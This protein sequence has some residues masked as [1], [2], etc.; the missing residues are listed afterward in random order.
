M[1]NCAA[2]LQ[3]KKIRVGTSLIPHRVRLF[4]RL[5]ESG[6]GSAVQPV[7]TL[8]KQPTKYTEPHLY[9]HNGKPIKG[10]SRSCHRQTCTE[11]TALTEVLQNL[12]R[13]VARSS[14]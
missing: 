2:T 9:Y 12:R 8:P 11:P 13:A 3:L 4:F 6:K 1:L 5:Q 10:G 7:P 14:P